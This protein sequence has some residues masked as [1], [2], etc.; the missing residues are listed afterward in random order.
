MDIIGVSAL[1][2][3]EQLRKI[4]MVWTRSR[5]A[6]KPIPDVSISNAIFEEINNRH[7]GMSDPTSSHLASDESMKKYINNIVMQ[8]VA[9]ASRRIDRQR[10]R[11][12]FADQNKGQ[13]NSFSRGP[14]WRDRTRA[15]SRA[16]GNR[17]Q[18]SEREIREQKILN[19]YYNNHP[20]GY[21]YHHARFGTD[22]RTCSKSD[23]TFKKVATPGN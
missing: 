18:L 2:S 1:P 14:S 16:Q 8:K 20:D 10:P 4:D 3:T 12:S 9:E 23:C 13:R 22:A 15:N 6:S 11:V 21:C 7:T 5:K 19:D 17:K